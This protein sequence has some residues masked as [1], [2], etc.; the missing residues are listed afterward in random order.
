MQMMRFNK[1]TPLPILGALFL[2]SSAA[3][4]NAENSIDLCNV[5]HE[6]Y[7][8]GRLYYIESSYVISPHLP[9][10]FDNKCKSKNFIL[11]SDT[12]LI[13][14]SAKT[15]LKIRNEKNKDYWGVYKIQ[16]KGKFVRRSHS[17]LN[18][19]GRYEGD[20]KIVEVIHFQKE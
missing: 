5:T 1:F 18:K 14:D 2:S 6:M 11:L 4:L 12:Y 7:G 10:A 16:F 9:Y 20:I 17:S 8:D 19:V 13:G 15:F 3:C